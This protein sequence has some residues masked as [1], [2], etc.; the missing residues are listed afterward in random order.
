MKLIRSITRM[1]RISRAL[2]AEKKTIGFVP[3]MGYLHEGHCS[4]VRKSVRE[5]D[6]TV[7]SI[8]VNPL[9]FGP[10]EDFTKYPRDLNRDAALAKKNGVDYLFVPDDSEMYPAS[11][12]TRVEVDGITRTMCGASRPGHFQGVTTVVAKLFNIVMPDSAYFGQKDI[13]QALVITAMARDL[14]LP[15]KIKVLPIVREPG[16]LAMS[17]RNAY[18]SESRRREV[19]IVYRALTAA[20]GLIRRGER[21]SAV[22]IAKMKKLLSTIRSVKI[23]YIVIVDPCGLLP[24]KKIAGTTII[25]AAIFVDNVRLID[26]IVIKV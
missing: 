20:R 23:D 4:L 6:V 12:R 11:Y 7:M 16:G 25:A 10:A 13:Q 15:I 2:K 1:Q 14:N 24:K 19:R 18:L 9:Q 22:I 5:C 21:R 3:T 17:S 8:Y 26:N